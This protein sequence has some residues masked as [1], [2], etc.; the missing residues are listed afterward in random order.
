MRLRLKVRVDSPIPALKGRNRTAQGV[1]PGV[2]HGELGSALKG[3]RSLPRPF[4]ARSMQH[5]VFPGLTP[6]A[7]LLDPFRVRASVPAPPLTSYRRIVTRTLGRARI[8][9]SRVLFSVG[10]VALL[11][12]TGTASGQQE[13]P[14]LTPQDFTFRVQSQLVQIYLTVTEG[15]RRVTDLKLSDFQLGEDGTS[16]DIDRLDSGTVPL[17]ITMLLDTSESMREALPTTQEAAVYFV[18]SMNPGDRVTLIPFNTDIRKIPQLTD[19]P[20]PIVNAIR[21]TQARGATKLYDSVLSAMKHLNGKEGRKAIVVFS[22]GEDTGR[23]SSLNIVLSAAARYGF[24]IYTIGAGAGLKRDS[25]KRVLRQLADINSGKAYFVEDP[26]ELRSAYVL[27]YYTQAPFDGRWHDVKITVSNPKH[28]V[29]CRKG[30]YAKSG[31]SGGLL[32][33]LGEPDSKV[34]VTAPGAQ[35]AILPVEERS[36]RVAAAEILKA[37]LPFRDVDVKPLRLFASRDSSERRKEDRRPI[38]KVESRFVEVP[39]L[40]ES[41]NGKELPD[42]TEKNFRV[43]EDDAL[44]EI[45]FFSKDVTKQSISQIREKALKKVSSAGPAALLS[46]ETQ[47][48]LLGRY[49]L[50]LDDL[51]S[52]TSAFLEGK[53]AAEKL[54]R[55]YHNPLR[56]L[57]V[58]FTSQGEAEIAPEPNLEVLLERVRKASPRADRDLTTNDNIM[59]VYEAYLIERGDRRTMELAELRIASNLMVR[60]RN[61]LGEVEG[62]EGTSPEVIQTQVVN[63]SRQLLMTNF[64]HVSRM[65]DGL[66]AV[67]SAASADPGTYPKVVVFM[68]SGFSLGRGSARADLAGMLEKVIAQAKQGGTRVY[69]IDASGLTVDEPL[70]IGASGA[71]LVRNPHLSSILAEH[72]RSWR[73]DRQSPLG[74]VADETGG[75]FLSS[76][77]DLAGAAG[78]ALRT[79]GQLY[80]LGYLSKQPADG[81]FHRIRVTTSLDGVRVH[82]RKGYYAGRQNTPETLSA[83]SMEGE[84]WETVLERANRARKA[85]DMKEL[86]A[87]LEQL[88]RRFPNQIDFWFNLGAA[89]LSLNNPERAVEALQKAFAL[90]PEDKN[91]GLALSQAFIA[92]GFRSAAQETLEL[93]TRRHPRDLGLLMQLG[94]VYESDARTGEAYKTYRRILD[95]VLSP[96]LDVYLLLTRTAMRLGRYVEAKLFIDDFLAQGGTDSQI[97][98]WRKMLPPR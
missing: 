85:G 46:S 34:P 32:T 88:V 73:Q 33:D 43:Y 52:E 25:L 2:R 36:A 42:L 11:F 97:D 38:F 3:R 90:S 81:R 9:K 10:L 87:A 39:V 83:T 93:M 79:V 45:A 67:V 62:Q 15:T 64:G 59:T 74:Q 82:G 56:P 40:L 13:K 29:H 44:R 41:L 60:Y 71:F 72:S 69:T 47:D 27:N 21:G 77:N 23:G 31:N 68:S 5:G 61:E 18:E 84:D 20:A 96:P 98:D 91:I 7:V 86:A 17:Q 95:L 28:K 65:M 14:D 80:Y 51:M 92:A 55:E 94:R 53:K 24:P 26:R 8:M 4:R 48:L 54:I 66:R 78:H 6:W 37:P 89:H 30:F 57:S 70:G 76:T 16:R 35:S 12:V 22:D 63:L 75:R 1:S 50:V 49:Y 58:H 19:D